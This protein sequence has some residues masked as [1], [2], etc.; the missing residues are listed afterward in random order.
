[1]KILDHLQVDLVNVQVDLRNPAGP[2]GPSAE[3]LD[4]LR[5][6]LNKLQVNLDP[7]HI[8]CRSTWTLTSEILQVDMDHLTNPGA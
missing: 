5:V 7:D 4:I 2:P 6:D 1:M 8:F 3:M